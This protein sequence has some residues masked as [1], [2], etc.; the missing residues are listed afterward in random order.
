MEP[1]DD[2]PAFTDRMDLWAAA[3]LKNIWE[4]EK[5]MATDC[6]E[7][8]NALIECFMSLLDHNY[9]VEFTREFIKNPLVAFKEVLRYYIEQYGSTDGD[10]RLE[11]EQRM[12]AEW[13]L[14]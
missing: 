1:S 7:M 4:Y 11:N 10:D 8:N 9:H 12:I 5:K 2:G 6:K 13:H 14:V 3:K